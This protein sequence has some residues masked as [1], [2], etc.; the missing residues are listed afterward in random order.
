MVFVYLGLD[1]KIYTIGKDS[2]EDLAHF[3]HL[4]LEMGQVLALELMSPEI[5]IVYYLMFCQFLMYLIKIAIW[6]KFSS[7]FGKT[8]EKNDNLEMQFNV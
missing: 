3:W 1:F 7:E 5:I 2:F 4:V 6:T 8:K